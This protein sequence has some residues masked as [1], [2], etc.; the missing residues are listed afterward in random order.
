MLAAR[1]TTTAMITILFQRGRLG[2]TLLVSVLRFAI[3]FPPAHV[4]Y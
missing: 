2:A 3:V 4:D 1:L